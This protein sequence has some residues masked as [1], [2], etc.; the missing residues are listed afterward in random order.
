[1]ADHRDEFVEFGPRRVPTARRDFGRWRWPALIV[2]WPM[3]PLVSR[4]PAE[5]ARNPYEKLWFR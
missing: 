3:W 5:A 4:K 2:L 1:M